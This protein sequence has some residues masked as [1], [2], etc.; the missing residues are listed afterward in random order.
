MYKDDYIMR[1]I[2]DSIRFLAKVLLNEDTDEVIVNEDNALSDK[3]D[4][5]YGSYY[6][7]KC[8]INSGKINEAENLLFERIKE[9]PN[10]YN[11]KTAL[12][13]YAELN[14]CSD[15]FLEE[16]DF[17]RDEILDGIH[18]IAGLYNIK[19]I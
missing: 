11:L 1:L 13:F 5:E 7:L 14:R 8:L 17:S 19:N 10:K 9:F 4:S 16:N 3:P 12:N 6:T 15:S 2:H 18:D